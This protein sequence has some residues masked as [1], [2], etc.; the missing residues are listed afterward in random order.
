MTARPALDAAAPADTGPLDGLLGYWL[1]RA[2]A[3]M[4]ADLGASLASVELRPTEATILI[5]I[6]N[7]PGLTQSELGRVLAIARANMAPLMAGLMKRGFIHK[8]RVDGRSQALALTAWGHD[9]VTQARAII[10]AHE[11]RF[12]SRL[13]ADMPEKVIEA[14]KQLGAS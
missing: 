12:Q 7:Q 11:H 2:S 13:A 5:L 14:L 6:G 9:K 4:M 3:V 10:D 1:R 8:S